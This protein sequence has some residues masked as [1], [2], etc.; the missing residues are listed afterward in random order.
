MQ[1]PEAR[2]QQLILKLT[3]CH[4]EWSQLHWDK[5]RTVL[6]KEKSI[7]HSQAAKL[8]KW[9]F[10]MK[11][12]DWI[13]E[14]GEEDARALRATGRSYLQE[15]IEQ[16][17]V[18]ASSWQV[19]RHYSRYFLYIFSGVT[20]GFVYHCKHWK[21]ARSNHLILLKCVFFFLAYCL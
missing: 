8:V 13:K 19:K 16:K 15:C 1:R 20:Q 17:K 11:L 7:L 10:S 12:S 18:C 21:R 3:C 6:K 4:H 9:L 5:Q 2:R 14:C